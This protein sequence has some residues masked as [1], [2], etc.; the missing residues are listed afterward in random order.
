M[1]VNK[2]IHRPENG[3]YVIDTKYA[4]GCSNSEGPSMGN[5]YCPDSNNWY[6]GT[7][8]TYYRNVGIPSNFNVEE[9]EVFQV[10]R[11]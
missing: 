5:L 7:N 11:K 6:Y 9:Y 2:L 4:V 8:G 3:P 10:I 1:L